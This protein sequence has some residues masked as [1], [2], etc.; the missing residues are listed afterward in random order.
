A[1]QRLL[2]TNGFA[3]EVGK[4][5][6]PLEVYR[7]NRR[8]GLPQFVTSDLLLYLHQIGY[9]GTLRQLEERHIAPLLH[10]LTAALLQASRDQQTAAGPLREVARRNVAYFGV[11]L[12]L[13]DPGAPLP[14]DVR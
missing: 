12:R 8:T 9:D 5:V 3:V 1:A 2:E 4:V 13:L 11:A 10:D 7:E 14:A 6:L